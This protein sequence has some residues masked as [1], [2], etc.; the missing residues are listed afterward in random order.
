MSL[1]LKPFLSAVE[2]LHCI[3]KCISSSILFSSQSGHI[4]LCFS[5]LGFVCLPFSIAKQWS[6]SR[7]F[8]IV[9]RNFLFC[10]FVKYFSREIFCLCVLYSV[11]LE[12][13]SIFDFQWFKWYE[14]MTVLKTHSFSEIRDE[15]FVS[16]KQ[17]HLNK[18]LTKSVV[19]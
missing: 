3:V 12:H 10:T 4:R 6:L 19:F 18:R 5:V 16:V 11:A 15:T 9:L 14:F 2:V 13:S 8:V 1:L 7:I 17:L